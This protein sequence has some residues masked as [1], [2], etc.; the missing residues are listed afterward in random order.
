MWQRIFS[1]IT[2]EIIQITRDRRTL[3]IIMAM[4]LIQMVMFGYVFGT[5]IKHISMVVWDAS[6][7]AES[8][9][10][11]QS[12]KAT[13]SL[14]INYYAT[15]YN[16]ITQRIESGDAKIALV[17]PPDFA[18][19][20][21]RGETATVQLFT[22]GSQPT[23][24]LQAL[25]SATAII[26]ARGAAL[27]SPTQARAAALPLSLDSRIWYN[28]A[29][30]SSLF[31]IPGLI[32]FILGSILVM[33]TAFSIVRERENGTIEQLN[34]SPLRRGELIVGKL[35]PYIFIAYAQIILILVTAVFVFGMPIRGSVALLLLLA[36]PFLMFSLG[37]GLIISSVSRTQMQATQT[38]QLIML[39]SVMLSGFMFPVESMPLIT[40]WLSA[41]FPLT[42]FLRVVRGII[43]KGVGIESLW[44]ETIILV[45]M[46]VLSLV[47]AALM[48]RKTLS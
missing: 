4:P 32:G 33:L 35:V 36:A 10:L 11:I 38:A 45:V 15:D 37:I 9:D 40:Q 8:R 29:L 43:V 18:V 7:T 16:D 34:V 19:S 48:M 31:Y 22:D 20:L 2:K 13:D 30:Q 21:H 1:I 46:G 17:I 6:K 42:Y 3:I 5:D 39:P 23:V 25:S 12:F 24:G 14:S 47:I 28:P 44:Q 41:L 27:M 26:Q